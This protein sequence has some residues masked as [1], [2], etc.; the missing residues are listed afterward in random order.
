MHP[1]KVQMKSF[2]ELNENLLSCECN[3]KAWKNIENVGCEY[4]CMT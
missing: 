3:V 4:T 2:K 1:A